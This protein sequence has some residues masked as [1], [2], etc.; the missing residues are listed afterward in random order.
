[1]KTIPRTEL[2]PGLQTKQA[3]YPRATAIVAEENE[4]RLEDFIRST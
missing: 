1:M 4:I 2:E 3:L